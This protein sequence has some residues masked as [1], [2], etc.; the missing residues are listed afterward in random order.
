M[1]V[2]EGSNQSAH[3]PRYNPHGVL[4]RRIGLSAADNDACLTGAAFHAIG[5]QIARFVFSE[6]AD[7]CGKVTELIR[8]LIGIDEI[9][10]H[11]MGA[12]VLAEDRELKR[13]I[14][15][16]ALPTFS[17]AS[18]LPEVIDAGR[19]HG[20]PRTS[21]SDLVNCICGFAGLLGFHVSIAQLVLQLALFG[22]VF[23]SLCC[24][25]FSLVR[26]TQPAR[27]WQCAVS[28]CGLS[29]RNSL[30]FFALLHW[31]Y[32]CLLEELNLA[33]VSMLV[34]RALKATEFFNSFPD[35]VFIL[36]FLL[37]SS[38]VRVAPLFICSNSN[39]AL[40]FLP[41][42][43][44]LFENCHFSTCPSVLSDTSM[45][46]LCPYRYFTARL[47]SMSHT[48]YTFTSVS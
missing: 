44:F 8:H 5:R 25:I 1:F 39:L 11:D 3:P 36:F 13:I 38:R 18:V 21:F 30:R 41:K 40:C 6:Q 47:F 17:V 9:V 22:T 28:E 29:N 33:R 20:K 7:A 12:I 2:F 24:H 27:D 14:S 34:M 32:Q 42:S 10:E 48:F 35:G 23:L 16:P 19:Q 4:F 37:A 46:Y 26:F 43:V 31:L 15:L 45:H